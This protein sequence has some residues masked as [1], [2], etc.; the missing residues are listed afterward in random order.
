[1][2]STCIEINSSKNHSASGEKTRIQ[3]RNNPQETVKDSKDHT[4]LEHGFEAPFH[5]V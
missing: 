1:M 2:E 4:V 5:M 3:T